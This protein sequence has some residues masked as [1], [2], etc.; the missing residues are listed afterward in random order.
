MASYYTRSDSP[1]FYVRVLKPDGTWG[2]KPSNIRKDS[3]GSLRKIKQ[4]VASETSKEP[5]ENYNR[6]SNWNNWVPSFLQRK[7]GSSEKTLKRYLLAWSAVEVYLTV[8]KCLTPTYVTYQ[9]CVDY[10]HWRSSDNKVLTKAC[11]WN[12]ALTEVKVFS[13]I[14]QEAVRRGYLGAN[15][16]FRLGLQRRNVKKKPRINEDEHLIIQNALKK[17]PEWMQESWEVAMLQGC[18]LSETAVPMVRINIKHKT[19]SFIGKGGKIHTSPLHLKLMRLVKKAKAEKREFL[20]YLPKHPSKCWSQFFDRIGLP[21]ITFH[22]T[23][24][25]VVTKLAL[26]GYNRQ[27]TKAY[28]GHA[29]DTVHDVY[30]RIEAPDVRHLGAVLNSRVDEN[31][32]FA[33]TIPKPNRL[34]KHHPAF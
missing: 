17:A 28:V 6:E 19:I 2:G 14:L 31:Q 9:K 13:V 8:I 34:L 30:T 11:N 15:P 1:Y 18:R 5:T 10:V 33:L 32:G 7:Y 3:L 29:S 24:V 4:L 22:S 21:H 26:A 12:T 16:C 23:R 25:T 20:V 27:M